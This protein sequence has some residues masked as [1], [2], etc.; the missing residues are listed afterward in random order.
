MTGNSSNV[1]A[2]KLSGQESLP[3]HIPI[4]SLDSEPIDYYMDPASGLLV[5][6]ASHHLKRGYCCGSGCRHCPYDK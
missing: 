2:T 3:P 4:P 1:E 6:T 5:F